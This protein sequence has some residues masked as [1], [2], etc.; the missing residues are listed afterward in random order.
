M[1]WIVM[2][3]NSFAVTLG[4]WLCLVVGALNPNPLELITEFTACTCDNTTRTLQETLCVFDVL[5]EYPA[6]NLNICRSEYNNSTCRRFISHPSANAVGAAVKDAHTTTVVVSVDYTMA[7]KQQTTGRPQFTLACTTADTSSMEAFDSAKTAIA[8]TNGAS[9]EV[10]VSSIIGSTRCVVLVARHTA[11]ASIAMKNLQLYL[12]R[13]AGKWSFDALVF[14]HRVHA[15]GGSL[16]PNTS[17]VPSSIESNIK[18]EIVA[19]AGDAKAYMDTLSKLTGATD[20]TLQD[21]SAW[22]IRTRNTYQTVQ[23][24]V[25]AEWVSEFFEKEAGIDASMQEF[26]CCGSTTARNVIATKPG[27]GS[28]GREI[29]VVGAH[30]DSLPSGTTAPGAV[31]NGSGTAAVMML[32]KVLSQYT[33]NRTIEFV[34]FGAEE[35]GIHGSAEYVRRA[36]AEGENIVAAFCLDMIGYSNR[37]F[38][39]TLEGTTNGEILKLLDLAAE[40]IATYSPKLE[41]KKTTT[42]FG[43]DHVSFQRAGIPAILGIELDDTN[44][45]HY[46]KATD[47]INEVTSTQAV[48]ILQGVAATLVDLAGLD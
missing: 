28:G 44:Y 6:Y 25:A 35:Q 36:Q 12:V 22:T 20:I 4:L 31:D 42:S 34:A 3:E 5:Q 16:R 33:F 1:S 41:V 40:N 15:S 21:G 14:P 32:A 7:S 46:H 30:M 2:V 27:D 29:V 11:S 8:T 17:H 23:S 9:S 24:L 10:A 48:D 18:D 19:K 13:S 26:T 45:P 37:F 39:V 47:T 38:G 43:S